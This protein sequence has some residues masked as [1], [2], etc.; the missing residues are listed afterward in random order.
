MLTIDARG[1]SCPQPVMLCKK[2]IDAGEEEFTILVDDPCAEGNIKRVGKNNNY[3]L[4]FIDK[5]N[6][7]KEIILKKEVVNNV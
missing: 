5:G 7:E 6:D 4:E 2:K 3:S 1:L